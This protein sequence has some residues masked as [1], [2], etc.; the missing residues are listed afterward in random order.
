MFVFTF[1]QI[2]YYL[3]YLSSQ[4]SYC[5]QIARQLH[6]QYVEGVNSN[7]VTLKSRLEIIEGRWKWHHSIDHN[8][9]YY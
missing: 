7:S 9:I 1:R 3:G 2:I 6:T 5:I 8:T 4:L